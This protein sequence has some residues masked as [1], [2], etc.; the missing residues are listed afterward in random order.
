M[1]TVVKSRKIEK[2]AKIPNRRP[3]VH[4]PRD[5]AH[6]N[7]WSKS[8]KEMCLKATRASKVVKWRK[9][10]KKFDLREK[11]LPRQFWQSGPPSLDT[12][13]SWKC[14]K[15][16]L[17]MQNFVPIPKNWSKYVIGVDFGQLTFCGPKIWRKWTIS[18]F[19][20]Y[21]CPDHLGLF[22]GFTCVLSRTVKKIV[23]I[24]LKRLEIVCILI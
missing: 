10:A 1:F 11:S 17:N 16:A 14:N 2:I 18:L 5:V 20:Y 4:C 15:W 22:F 6:S 7:Y 24:H 13:K 3:L 23:K 8:L 12:P 21:N 9:W 19:V